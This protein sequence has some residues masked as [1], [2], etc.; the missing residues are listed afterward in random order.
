M[1]KKLTKA[2]EKRR[3]LLRNILQDQDVGRFYTQEQRMKMVTELEKL[4]GIKVKG[5]ELWASGPR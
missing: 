2:Q 3:I 5:N 1:K 4:E